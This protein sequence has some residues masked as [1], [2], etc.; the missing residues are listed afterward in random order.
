VSRRGWVRG[1]GSRNV[2][3]ECEGGAG[4]SNRLTAVADAVGATADTWDAETGSFTYDVNGNQLTARGASSLTAATYDPRN[5][6]LS[7]T[8]AGTATTYRYDDAGQR[9]PKQVGVG[10]RRAREC[11]A[12]E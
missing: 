1:P 12:L 8:R 10:N 3:K 7:L 11:G 9:I 6:P 4:T 5:L 2:Q